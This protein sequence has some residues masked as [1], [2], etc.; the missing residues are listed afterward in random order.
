MLALL[1]ATG[2]AGDADDDTFGD[3]LPP[4]AVRITNDGGATWE[5]G[6][7]WSVREEWR[8]GSID[9]AA[10]EQFAVPVAL[11]EDRA[12][13]LYV[14]DAQVSDVRVFDSNGTHVR[15]FGGAGGGPGEFAQPVGL[16]G[17]PDGLLWVADP[18]N[19]R[20]TA[21]DTTGTVQATQARFSPFM[22]MPWPGA[23]D[24]DGR[25]YDVSPGAELGDVVLLRFPPGSPT[26][27]TVPLPRYRGPRFE[28]RAGRSE[29]H[30]PVPFAAQLVW[31]VAPDGRLW[32]GVPESYRMAVRGTEGAVERVIELP[33]RPVSASVAEREAAVEA[34]RW[35]TDQGGRI[36][37][38]RI[39]KQKPA[40]TAIRFDDSGYAWV[41]PAHAEEDTVTRFDVFT[42][43]GVFVGSVSVPVP[44]HQPDILPVLIRGDRIYVAALDP[45]GFPY[46]ARFRIAGRAS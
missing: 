37:A 38:S 5:G 11:E 43:G 35:F 16:V 10:A 20:L 6:P 1:T 7:V 18:G 46:I 22:M 26:A 8:I 17:A 29:T 41:S 12:G 36:D 42:P 24:R 15:S 27:D 45:A 14:L 39:P 44:P 32:Y 34:L 25:L 19:V 30:A 28:F 3:R 21:F 4:G 13:R 33:A 2:C 40:Y 31:S 23:F 9:G